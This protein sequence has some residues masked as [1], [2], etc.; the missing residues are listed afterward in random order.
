MRFWGQ[1]GLPTASEVK[2][3]IRFEI[4]GP[5]Y[6]CNHVYLDCFDLLLESDRKK[7]ERKKERK[8]K[9]EHLALLD[10]S[11]SPQVKIMEEGKGAFVSDVCTLYF[12]FVPFHFTWVKEFISA[13]QGHILGNFKAIL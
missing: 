11:A 12:P 5:N 10:L 9:E 2:S 6:I 1:Y 8:K 7:K 3:E 13:V 4:Y